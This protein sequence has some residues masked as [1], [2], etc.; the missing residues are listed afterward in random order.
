MNRRQ[1]LRGAALAGAGAI[2]GAGRAWA[3]DSLWGSGSGQTWSNARIL[4][5]LMPGDWPVE[6]AGG[7]HV[8]DGTI[9]AIGPEVTGGIDL[10]G[11]T[12]WPGMWETGT[13][14]GI[15][16]IDLEPATRD[17]VESGD[18]LEPQVRVVDAFNPQSALQPVLRAR[19]VMGALVM[20]GGGVVSGQAAWMRTSGNT[21]SEA[22]VLAPAGLVINLGKAGVSAGGATSRM[23]VAARLRDVLEANPPP[24]DPPKPS[25]WKRAPPP[26]T[27]PKPP[28]RAEAVWHD[29]LSW[30][31]KAIFVADRA[32]DIEL[33]LGLAS[34]YGLDAVIVGAAEGWMLADELSDAGVP[35]V[36]GPVTAQPDSF[37]HLRARYDN[38]ALLHAAGVRLAIRI[39]DPHRTFDLSTEAGIAV[40]WGLPYS[41]AVA[42]ITG[43]S[44]DFFGLTQGR[45]VTGREAT[46][47]ISD[48]DPLEPRTSVK[49]V[50]VNGVEMPLVNHQTELY[51]RFRVLK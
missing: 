21:V 42:A 47:V 3:E 31:L 29:L 26:A 14:M 40:A 50:V 44:P 15:A 8:Q 32:S 36:L 34:D 9:V 18:P 37:D 5:G 19:G 28:T 24:Q 30:R 46:F 16:E 17:D 48:G 43:N 20:P 49:H 45:L 38:A 10:G 25:M 27:P 4:T 12:I 22:T 33:A 11:A 39:G 51:D 1:V 6:L 7:I 2:G 41:V 35:V 23:G 13:S